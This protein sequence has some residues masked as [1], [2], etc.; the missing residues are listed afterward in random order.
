METVFSKEIQAGLD[1]ARTASLKK[2]S[3]LRIE[4]DGVVHPVLRM[5]K[6]GFAIAIEDAPKLRGL[7]DIFDGSKHLFQCLIVA[8]EEAAPGE[9][10]YE[11]KRATAVAERAALDFELPDGTPAGLITDGS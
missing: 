1:A 7:V 3:R 2:A 11:F 9:M 4:V 8:T 6:T 10:H 5:W